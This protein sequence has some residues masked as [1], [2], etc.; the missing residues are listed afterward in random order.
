MSFLKIIENIGKD[1]V[2]GVEAAGP[3]L[4]ATSPIVTAIDPPI[5]IILS[6]IGAVLT[7]IE[8]AHPPAPTGS[9][10]ITQEQLSQLIQA[11]ATVHAVGIT[12]STPSA[13][14]QSIIVG[15]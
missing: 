8:K 11:L 6:E 1:I 14:P 4:V 13:P 12:T 15:G 10:A 2:K 3:I 5:G 7:A 9:T